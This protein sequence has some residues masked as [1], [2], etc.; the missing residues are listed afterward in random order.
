[1]EHARAY[2]AVAN[3]AERRHPAFAAE[4]HPINVNVGTV[5]GGE[6]TSSVATRATFSLRV[7]VM[8][9]QSCHAVRQE[10]EAMVAAAGADARLRGARLA[11]AFR[12]FMADGCVFPADQPISQAVSALHQDVSGTPLRSYNATGL[13]DARFYALYQGTQAT[14]YGPDGDSIHGIDE[15]VGLDSVQDVTRVLA[16]LI[17]GWCGVEAREG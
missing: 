17:A 2:E 1:M 4:N 6:W 13:T 7:G 15:S 16:L 8:P 12:G 11:L 9:G 5:Q 10:I 14:C 3:R